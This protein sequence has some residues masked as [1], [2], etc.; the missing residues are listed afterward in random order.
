[1]IFDPSILHH[2]LSFRTSRSGGKGG[3]N[4]NKV[5]TKVELLFDVKSS[6]HLSEEQK[7]KIL[8]RLQN[9]ITSEGILQIISQTERSQYA[10]KL[11]ALNQFDRLI[12]NAFV[13]KKKRIATKIS[14]AAKERRLQSKKIVSEKKQLRRDLIRSN[15]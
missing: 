8:Q 11:K 14:K 5:S 9:R 12:R 4:V 13:E 6:V 2:E 7:Q 10:N 3:Q 1:V 15:E